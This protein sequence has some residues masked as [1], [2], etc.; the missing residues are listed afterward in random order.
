ME[1]DVL[2]EVAPASAYYIDR[3][4]RK[5]ATGTYPTE[6]VA[7]FCGHTEGVLVCQEDRYGIPH[8]M[9][10]CATCGLIYASQR[11]TADAY[12]AFYEQEYRQIY[13]ADDDDAEEAA[14]L[15]ERG[16]KLLKF[17][18]TN[19]DMTPAVVMELGC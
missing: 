7:C 9:K 17:L 1:P 10:V 15:H 5:L 4:K 11:M 16:E 6:S 8:P 13:G 2:A 3:V 12:R 14:F 18:R 19:C